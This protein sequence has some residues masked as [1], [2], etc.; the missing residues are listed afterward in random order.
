MHYMRKRRKDH[1]L[2]ESH[3]LYHTWIGILRRCYDSKFFGYEF[4]G[5]KGITVCERWTKDFHAFVEDMGD[6]PST[7][8]SI[9]RIDGTKGYCPENC[10]W[11]TKAEQGQNTKAT[12]LDANIVM[13]IRDRI[14]I[15]EKQTDI[16]KHFNCS[17]SVINKVATGRTWKD[18]P[19]ALD[20]NLKQYQPTT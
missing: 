18:V 3:P 14:S 4:Y 2:K 12:V 19:G 8:Y 11:A 5:A 6:K 9:D 17:A 10:R 1:D 13:E 20:K 16:A 15:G 7:E